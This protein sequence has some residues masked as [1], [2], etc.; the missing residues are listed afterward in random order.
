MVLDDARWRGNPAA[1]WE[2][3][4]TR[5]AHDAAGTADGIVAIAQGNDFV[6]VSVATTTDEP[7]DAWW[8]PIE[9]VS[10]SEDGF[11]RV[12]QGSGLLLSWPLRMERGGRWSRTVHHVVSTSHDRS[13]D[14][15]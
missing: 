10:N 1:W 11:E 6:G 5:A 4:G 13:R 14:E 12:Y 9:T 15:A 8:A 2:S 3:D 7:A